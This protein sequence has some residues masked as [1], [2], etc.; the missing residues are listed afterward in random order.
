MLYRHIASEC[1]KVETNVDCALDTQRNKYIS[2]HSVYSALALFFPLSFYRKKAIE[3]N[4]SMSDINS[5]Q[6]P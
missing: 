6:T 5:D 3:I 4:I 1:P 2:M